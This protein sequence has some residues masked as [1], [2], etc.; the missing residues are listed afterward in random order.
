MG[1]FASSH[2]NTG[3]KECDLLCPGRSTQ[4]TK[5]NT[6]QHCGSS[7]LVARVVEDAQAQPASGAKCSGLVELSCQTIEFT[8][9]LLHTAHDGVLQLGNVVAGVGLP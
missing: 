8:D 2:D 4:N 5:V 3:N 7:L 1:Y 6:M 9:A